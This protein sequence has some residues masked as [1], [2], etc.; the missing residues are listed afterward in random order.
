MPRQY[1]LFYRRTGMQKF[2]PLS[3]QEHGNLYDK[4]EVNRAVEIMRDNPSIEGLCVRID[5]EQY[6][7]FSFTQEA[8]APNGFQFPSA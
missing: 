3:P 2:A 1:R 5:S 4:P 7:L 8:E 6:Q